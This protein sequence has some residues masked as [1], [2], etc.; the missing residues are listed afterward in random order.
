M[1]EKKVS[2]DF[3]IIFRPECWSPLELF[4]T[5]IGE[6][7]PNDHDLSQGAKAVSDHLGKFEVLAGLANRLAQD[8]HLDNSELQERG[9]TPAI[10]SKEYAAV[11]EALI[12]TLYSA[13]DGLRQ[14]LYGAY[15][16]VRRVQNS[17]NQRMFNLATERGYGEEFPEAIRQALAEANATW[18]PELCRIRTELTHHEVGSCHWDPAADKIFYVH[19]GLG[20]ATR[21]HLIEDVPKTLSDLHANVYGLIQGVFQYLAGQ[22]VPVEKVVFCGIYRGRIYLRKVAL[23]PDMTFHSGTCQSRQWFDKPEEHHKCPLRGCCGAY[24]RVGPPPAGDSPPPQ[25]VPVPPSGS[26]TA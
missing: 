19:S 16:K 6:P 20:S 7:F 18:F 13:L 3:G 11:V 12:T 5:F 2:N 9:H 21:A 8:L 23:T 1:A 15:K 22:L 4:R 26:N 24:A 14:T 10:R 17:S 25:L